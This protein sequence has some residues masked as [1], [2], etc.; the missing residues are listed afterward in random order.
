[1]KNIVVVSLL[2]FTFN[3]LMAQQELATPEDL[4]AWLPGELAGYVQDSDN[5]ASEQQVQG[6]SY[7]I[8]AKQYKKAD[9]S[10]SVVII[11]YRKNATEITSVTSAWEDGKEIDN[12][13]I[14]SRNTSIANCKAKEVYDKKSNTSQVY[15]YR[16]D[17]YQITL[18]TNGE[19]L[20][21]LKEM[22]T[23]LP[24]GRLP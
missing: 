23:N 13:I 7:F 11:D 6:S 19:N 3:S 15:L 12:G 8:A 20:G 5:H 9:K 10:I 17:R 24:L 18:S 22:I 1:M 14:Q 2:I 4:K 21:L 16:A